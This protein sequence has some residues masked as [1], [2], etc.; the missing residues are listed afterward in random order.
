M[1]A[2]F[3]GLIVFIFIMMMSYDHHELMVNQVFVQQ[4]VQTD[5]RSAFLSLLWGES[6]GNRWFLHCWIPSTKGLE[7]G[8]CFHLMTIWCLF[9]Q[10][11]KAAGWKIIAVC[12]AVY[13]ILYVYERLTWTNKNK[14]RVF[15]RQYVN[16]ATGKLR[17]IVDLTS[18]NCGDQVQRWV[19]AVKSWSDSDASIRYNSTKLNMDWYIHS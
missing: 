9:C 7:H 3:S 6:T 1:A 10:V 14:E 12:G 17:L 11:A 8:K 18:S 16:H 4:F 13:G 19:N 15:K 5:N 2:I